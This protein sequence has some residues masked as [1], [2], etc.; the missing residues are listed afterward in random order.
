MEEP[1]QCASR[2]DKLEQC[3]SCPSLACAANGLW[4]EFNERVP[5]QGQE[6]NR[7]D[8]QKYGVNAALPGI[9]SPRVR[10]GRSAGTVGVPGTVD[11]L[12][13]VFHSVDRDSVTL[14]IW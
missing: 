4:D 3:Q 6:H 12:G 2:C 13:L 11:V 14:Y 9:G 10:V 1:A 7:F 8:N 5:D